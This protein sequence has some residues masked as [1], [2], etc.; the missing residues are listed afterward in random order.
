MNASIESLREKA[1]RSITPKHKEDGEIS[2]AESPSKSRWGAQQ[3][4]L[5]DISHPSSTPRKRK[6]NKKYKSDDLEKLITETMTSDRKIETLTRQLAHFKNINK[7]SVFSFLLSLQHKSFPE[8]HKKDNLHT[9]QDI[10]AGH[11]PLVIL[12]TIIGETLEMYDSSYFLPKYNVSFC[13]RN[14][15]LMDVIASSET[16]A[17]YKH[18][19]NNTSEMHMNSCALT[20][21]YTSPL[22]S[23]KNLRFSPLYIHYVR[24]QGLLSATFNNSIE[25]NRPICK[26]DLESCPCLLTSCSYQ[27]LK[28]HNDYILFKKLRNSLSALLR[29]HSL[30]SPPFIGRQISS[31]TPR[32]SVITQTAVLL[33]FGQDKFTGKYVCSLTQSL[34]ARKRVYA[35]ASD[36]MRKVP[37]RDSQIISVPTGNSYT[38]SNTRKLLFLDNNPL[39]I[40]AWYI[41]LNMVLYISIL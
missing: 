39:E 13:A 33:K 37:T 21:T 11:N 30:E 36:S 4:K 1:L 3:T 41:Y 2:D 24:N 15:D 10:K 12:D 17:F 28:S 5:A 18:P 27:H 20:Y 26:Q 16:G 29:F 8:L 7:N 34:V 32:I 14:N 25:F 35:F 38:D 23:F 31:N 9:L 6:R 22:V 40:N 19:L